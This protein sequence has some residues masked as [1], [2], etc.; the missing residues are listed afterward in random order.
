VCAAG[1]FGIAALLASSSAHAFC[2]TTT[3]AP[4]TG[5]DPAAQ[6][7]CWT[8]GIPIA[9]TA[10][11]VPYGI[12]SAASKY[13]TLS[14]AER[15]ADLA[16]AQWN[17]ALCVGGQ[18]SVQAYDVGALDVAPDSG[19]CTT[20]ST[21]NAVTHDVIVFRDQMWPHDDPV[22]TLALT[23]VTYGVNDGEIFEAYTEVNSA[24]HAL[25]TLEPPPPGAGFDLQAI[26]THEAGHFLGLAHAT[27]THSIMYAYYQAGAI[28]LTPDDVGAICAVYQPTAGSSGCSLQSAPAGQGL[29]A[30]LSGLSFVMLAGARRR[31]RR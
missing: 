4:P 18:P 20:S 28:N 10:G 14:E 19:D 1:A 15:V 27:D 24:Q 13:V 5:Y 22:N 30:A 23:T 25:T 17:S 12:S 9:W 6:K 26:L 8:K 3:S 29:L 16:F 2:R 31:R 11:K 21:C 7:A